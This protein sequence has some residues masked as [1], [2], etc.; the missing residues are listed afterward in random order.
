ML[1]VKRYVDSVSRSRSTF[2]DNY[3]L[4]RL[5]DI[6]NVYSDYDFKFECITYTFTIIY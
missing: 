2:D 5:D 3:K 6:V 4:V 1:T